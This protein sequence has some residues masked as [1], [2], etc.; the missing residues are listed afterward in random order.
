MKCN[1]ICSPPGALGQ[2]EL[3]PP[4]S[5]S[6]I[7]VLM[8]TP[9]VRFQSGQISELLEAVPTAERLALVV[10]V[11]HV[12]AQV[13]RA[14]ELP[15]TEL[16]PV[17]ADVRMNQHVRLEV[18]GLREVSLAHVAHERLPAA[19]N[20]LRVPLQVAQLRKSTPTDPARKRSPSGVRDRVRPELG[21]THPLLTAHLTRPGRM[22]VHMP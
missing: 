20:R 21:Q 5:R 22:R 7:E 15:R 12:S 17:P 11:P 19:V 4:R 2:F 3:P 8:L 18:P 14:R 6:L 16:A 13:G 9:H 1:N 10:T